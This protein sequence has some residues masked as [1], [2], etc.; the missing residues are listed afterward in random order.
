LSDFFFVCF[1][2]VVVRKEETMVKETEFYDRLGVSPSATPEEIKKAYRKLAMKLHPDR[3]PDDPTAEDKFKALGE[4]Y[5]VLSDPEKKRIYDKYG[6]EGLTEGPSRSAEDIFSAFFGSSFFGG[7]GRRDRGPR[8]SEDSV[9]ALG[10]TL[11]DLYNG[12][13]HKLQITRDVLCKACK[14]TGIR[15]G[16]EAQVCSGCN[17]RGMRIIRRQF[18][19]MVQQMQ[20]VCPDC[21]GTGEMT[22][23]KDKCHTCEGRKLQKEKKTIELVIEPGMKDNQKLVFPGDADEVPGMEPGDLIFVLKTQPHKDF[24][25][26]GNNLVMKK[27][28]LLS[29]ALLGCM[30]V[31]EHLDKRQIVV[32]S[33]P[34][35]VIKPGDVLAVPELGMPILNKPFQFGQLLVQ[36]DVQYP[37]YSQLKDPEALRNILPTPIAQSVPKPKKPEPKKKNQKKNTHTDSSDMEEDRFPAAGE[38]VEVVLQDYVEERDNGYHGNAYDSDDSDDERRGGA[39]EVQCASQ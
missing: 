17:G 6:K 12:T 35:Q 32:R 33:A 4:A 21:H 7:G 37:L 11:E 29:E 39:Q 22:S 10:V 36:F 30:F 28:I 9:N 23:D 3:N 16:R 34:H 13:R 27:T 18:G 15:E 19:P 1:V 14:G 38:V 31:F 8:K 20:V 25:R 26:S 2:V 24:E 5:D